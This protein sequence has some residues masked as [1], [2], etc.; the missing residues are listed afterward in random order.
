MYVCSH[1]REQKNDV[2][3]VNGHQDKTETEYQAKMQLTNDTETRRPRVASHGR[4]APA[5][6]QM[7]Q[8]SGV[9]SSHRR[10]KTVEDEQKPDFFSLSQ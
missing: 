8:N 3:A 2:A 6:T 4:R 7:R 9:S 10:H 5:S 1:H